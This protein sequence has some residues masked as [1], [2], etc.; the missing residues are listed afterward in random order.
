[1]T[2][3]QPPT[4]QLGLLFVE[5]VQISVNREKQQILSWMSKVNVFTETVVRSVLLKKLFLKISQYLH[6]IFI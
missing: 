1:M 3:W 5:C 6:K 2:V 4:I